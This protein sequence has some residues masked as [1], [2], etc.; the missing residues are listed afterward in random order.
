MHQI[1]TTIDLGPKGEVSAVLAG[2]DKASDA[3]AI[4]LVVAH[5]AGNDMHNPLIVAVA[6]G[7]A[8]AGYPSL[9]FNFPYKEKGKKSPD[10]QAT[11][12][13][14]WRCALAF[15]QANPT[16][17]IRDI[18]AVGKSMGG[19]VASQMAAARQMN[20]A[21]LIFLG[22]PLHAP[23]RTDQLRDAHLY[24]IDAPMLFVAGT[25]DSLCKLDKLHEVLGRLTGPHDLD[26]VD[27]GDHSFR[28]P[29]T[30][31]RTPA[32]VQQQVVDRCLAWLKRFK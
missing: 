12:V 9:R 14:T 15:M 26:T 16:F 23:G 30:V 11:L 4:G 22:Y 13:H 5:G 20:V 21:G 32:Q 7:M 1:E 28:L 3:H 6:R 24:A 8:T 2:P 10:G 19:R 17:P 31:D 25:R 29:Q 18:I 27:G